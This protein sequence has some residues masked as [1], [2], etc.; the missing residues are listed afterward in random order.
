MKARGSLGWWSC[1]LLLT[2]ASGPATGQPQPLADPTR[3]AATAAGQTAVA[4]G[5]SVQSIIIGPGRRR[6]AIIDGERVELGGR[7]GEATVVRITDAGV[8][9]R[10]SEGETFLPASAGVE[11]TPVKRKDRK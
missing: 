10:G 1:L 4:A 11:K 2:A 8:V 3:P 5:P 6:A 9:L 7:Y